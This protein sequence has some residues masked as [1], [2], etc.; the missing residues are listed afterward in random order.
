MRITFNT[1]N[2][3]MQYVIANRYE[4]LSQLQEQLS[5]GKRLLRPSDDPVDVANDL[6]LRAKS[7]QLNQYQK[8]IED[9]L[10]YMS[11]TDTTMMSMN[12]L[13]Q[14]MREL[15]IQGASDTQ[16]A[17]ERNF[18]AQEVQQLVRQVVGL[19][20]S[21]YKGDYIFGG[22]HT[23]IT[24]FPLDT[25][26]ATTPQDYADLNMAYYDA[27][28]VA[29]GTAVQ[30]RDAFDTTPVT[31]IMPGTFNLSVAGV[32][33]T[34]G[35][36]Y[37]VDYVNGTI[38][39]IPTSPHAAQL[40]A[41]VLN[42]VNPGP[43]ALP[44]YSVNGFQM[45]FEYVSQGRDIFGD[46]VAIDGKILR[47]V[48]SGITLPINITGEELI[49]DH[50]NGT[51]LFNV[52]IDLGQSL[53]HND[54]DGIEGSIGQ[55]DL[56]MKNLLA[57]QSTNGARVNRFDLTIERNELQSTETSRQ[58]S[59]LEDAEYAETA[60]NFSTLQTVYEAALKSAAKVLQPS[61]ANFI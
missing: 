41:D 5:T 9:G 46:Q 31:N 25:S 49:N 16:S 22:T 23:K 3:H 43:P 24:P 17:T 15:A 14:R 36:D 54:R 56:S 4:D 61:L 59:E 21:E 29:V 53:I 30:I 27:S 6:K 48:E 45:T 19:A 11:V 60:M 52:I 42:G 35:T 38:A 37:T 18:I 12:E 26:A 8:N 28:A 1:V 32:K 47:E 13:M 44:N 50:D 40:S 33:M 10:G 57:A 2:R 55:L 39:V 7:S 58:Q 51:N 20:N 34:E